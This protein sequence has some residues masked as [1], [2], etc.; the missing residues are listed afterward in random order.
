MTSLYRVL[1]LD[2]RAAADEPGGALWWPRVL[3][4]A[5]RHDNQELYGCMYVSETPLSAIAEVLAPFRGTGELVPEMLVRGER[6]LVLADLSLEHRGETL[7]DLDD[8]EVLAAESLRPS[9]V[10]TRDRSITQAWAGKLYEAH[11]DAPG[12][13][14]WST[15]EASWINVTLFD[16]AAP[17]LD[18]AGVRTLD[19]DD[20]AV[21]EAAAFLG[22]GADRP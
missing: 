7:V 4:G 13:R 16:R 3:Q 20:D 6:Q 10:A 2:R 14:W 1:P 19:S 12:L 18:V 8:G 22:V 9:R 15:L 11:P 17:A 5:G 21:A